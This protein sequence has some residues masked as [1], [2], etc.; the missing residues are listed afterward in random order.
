MQSA[1]SKSPSNFSIQLYNIDIADEL[2]YLMLP[3]LGRVANRELKLWTR[4]PRPTSLWNVKIWLHDVDSFNKWAKTLEQH[5]EK[6]PMALLLSNRWHADIL[7]LTNAASEFL[8]LEI[9]I[10]KFLTI[11]KMKFVN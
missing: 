6:I 1:F 10:Y 8:T 5:I 11:E 4:N 2:A 9:K 3:L 7:E